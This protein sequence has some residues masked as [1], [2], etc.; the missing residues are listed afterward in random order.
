MTAIVGLSAPTARGL[1]TAALLGLFAALGTTACNTPATPP[2]PPDD[3][4]AGQPQVVDKTVTW[5][6]ESLVDQDARLALTP[7][8]R[9]A[10]ELSPVPVLAVAQS[11]LLRN[12][13]ITRGEAF[14]AVS[15]RDDGLIVSLH[16]TARAHRYPG[17][18]PASGPALVRGQAAFVTRNEQIWS[19]SWIEGGVAYSLE[20]ECA[21]LPDARCDDDN[22]LLQLAEALVYLGGRGGTP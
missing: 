21:T 12:A 5:P 11:Q 2:G 15:S 8:A 4:A 6:A 16:A 9:E 19:A 14:A 22:L 13:I 17:V 18:K 20:L 7:S 1:F 10:I 3:P